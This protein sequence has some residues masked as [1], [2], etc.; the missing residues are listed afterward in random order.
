MLKDL[1]IA[2][3][4]VHIDA[5]QSFE[6]TGL[7]LTDLGLLIN[8]Y[9]TPIEAL[10]ESRL[11]LSEIANEFPE[12]MAKAIAFAAGEPNEWEQVKKLP[13]ALQL[14]AFEDCWDLTIPDYDA[15]GKLVDRV[16]GLI[17]KSVVQMESNSKQKSRRKRKL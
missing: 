14:K 3:K 11:D 15:L 5:D 1:V 16:K 4:T 8:E 6:V 12:F 10:M 17:P 2:S 13:F 7:T 9:K